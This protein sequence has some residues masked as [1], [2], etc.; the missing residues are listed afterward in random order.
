MALTRRTALFSLMAA[1]ALGLPGEADARRKSRRRSGGG[2]GSRAAT[3]G[4][5]RN[6]SEARAAGRRRIRRGDPDYSP[7]LDRDGDGV[8]CE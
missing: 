2:G 6:C 5:F 7:H 8:A 3:G 1:V 4:G